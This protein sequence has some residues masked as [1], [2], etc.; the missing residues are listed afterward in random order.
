MSGEDNVMSVRLKNLN[1]YRKFKSSLF[2][3]VLYLYDLWPLF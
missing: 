2:K 3:D 1:I